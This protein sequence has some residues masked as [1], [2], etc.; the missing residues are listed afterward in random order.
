MRLIGYLS[1]PQTQIITARNVGFFPVVKAELPA[2]L[3]PGLKM[4]AAAIAEMQSARDAVPALLPVGLG[5]RGGEFDNVFMDTFQLIVLHGQNPRAVLD[6]EAETLTRL[7]AETGAPCWQPD[8]PS[9]G[10]CRLQ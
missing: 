10:A 4:A 5:Q 9:A 2:D 6:R 7:L 3:D 8:P 1:Q